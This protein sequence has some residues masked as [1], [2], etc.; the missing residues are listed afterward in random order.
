MNIEYITR[1]SNMPL[2]GSIAFGIIDR[3]T[4]LLQIR[5]TTLCN[6]NCC[7]CSTNSGPCSNNHQTEF[8]VEADYLVDYVKEISNFKGPGIEANI[9][10][11]GEP[12]TYK[13]LPYL[14]SKIS[15][16]KN[17]N[18]ISMQ[19][20]A[21]LLTPSLLKKLENSGLN[22][23]NLS[24]HTLDSNQAKMLA[25]ADFYD[26]RKILNILPLILKSK[27]ELVLTPV[28]IPN[29]N[30]SQFPTLINLAKELDVKIHI[31]KYE[32][33][34]YSRKIKK[35]KNITYF[36]FYKQLKEWESKYNIKLIYKSKDLN[37][38]KRKSI[39]T[40]FKKGD[41][42]KAEIKFNGWIKGQMLAKAKNRCITL[43]N[44]D[45]N[46]NDLVNAKIIE[47]KSNIYLAE[48][49]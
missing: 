9:D 24:L 14:I 46:I 38:T 3:G 33:Y 20:N 11:V 48:Q 31:Q 41:K 13:D 32:T 15:K 18:F 34:K 25:G 40:I 5:P 37:I 22:R 29:I 7:F 23:I 8:D 10:S 2:V 42:I 28:Y 19:T 47:S 4:N 17:I 49:N 30:K 27:I 26:L 21:T 12:L 36:K 1:E 6:L 16:L 45:K 43:I 44:V 39:P 35:A